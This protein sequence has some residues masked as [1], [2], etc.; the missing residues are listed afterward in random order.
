MGFL[1]CEGSA[2]HPRSQMR[3]QIGLFCVLSIAILNQLLISD[4]RLWFQLEGRVGAPVQGV[5]VNGD[6]GNDI[7]LFQVPGVK[8]TMVSN[9]H[10]ELQD[11]VAAHPSPNIFKVRSTFQEHASLGLPSGWAGVV[12]TV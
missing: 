12:E 8:G 9:A 5:L 6:S 2:Y 1:G 7:E 3:I 4:P 11:W 10:P